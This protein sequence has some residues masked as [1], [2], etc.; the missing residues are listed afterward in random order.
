MTRSVSLAMALAG[1]LAVAL[2]GCAAAPIDGDG[3]TWMAGD[4]PN[5]MVLPRL[6]GDGAVSLNS[7]FD[8]LDS[9]A[10][11]NRADCLSSENE[12]ADWTRTISAPFTGPRFLSVTVV[13]NYYCGG[14]HPSVDLRAMTFDRR[15]GGLPDWDALWPGAGITATTDGFGNLPSVTR[16][17]ALVGWFRAAVRENADNDAEWLAQCEAYYGD[18]PV[19]ETVAIWLDAKTGGIGMDWV[20][21][22]HAAMA[23]GSPQVMPTETAVRL[24]A[25]AELIAALREGRRTHSVHAPSTP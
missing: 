7:L 14:A 6:T 21:L 11:E 17:A 4:N 15:T 22:P 5:Q 19:D 23:C 10:Q 25:S 24:G 2:A 16:A 3:L 13:E 1:T 20:S 18:A 9:G 12:N 8:Q